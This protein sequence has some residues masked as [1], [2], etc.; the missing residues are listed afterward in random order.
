MQTRQPPQFIVAKRLDAE[1]QAIDAGVAERREPRRG[2]GFGV[3]LERDFAIGRDVE[4]PVGTR[5]DA[6]DVVGCEQGRRS[7]AEIDRVR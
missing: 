4:R 3:G 5:D 7:A 2:N 6:C 1:T